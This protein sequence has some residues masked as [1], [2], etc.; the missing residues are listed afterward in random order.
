MTWGWADGSMTKPASQ[1]PQL[2]NRLIQF[3]RFSAEKVAIEL[4]RLVAAKHRRDFVQRETSPASKRDQRQT[5]QYLWIEGA[6]E[7]SPS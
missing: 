5:P 1:S 3:F 6:A 7:P 4:R 2:P